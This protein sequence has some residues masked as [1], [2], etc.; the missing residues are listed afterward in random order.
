MEQ[1]AN[2]IRRDRRF[3]CG[4]GRDG[5]Y[6]EGEGKGGHAGPLLGLLR[7]LSPQNRAPCSA[8]NPDHRGGLTKPGGRGGS[9]A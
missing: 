2:L 7:G 1:E 5:D 3:V 4:G 8:P 6:S 9:T